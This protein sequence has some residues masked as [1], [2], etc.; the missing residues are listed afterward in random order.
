MPPRRK[1]PPAPA[2]TASLRLS[3]A[4]ERLAA[5]QMLR[6]QLLGK[7]AR[8]KAALELVERQAHA[9]VERFERE[10][11]R[12]VQEGMRLDQ[13]VHE[14]L[15]ALLGDG[16]RGKAERAAVRRVYRFLMQDQIITPR[17]MPG[18]AARGQ[19]VRPA[20]A[21][22]ETPQ[23]AFPFDEAEEPM[24]REVASAARP[25]DTK[26]GQLRTLFRRLADA[27]HPDKVQD[28]AEKA[29]CTELMKDITAAYRRGDLAKLLEIERRWLGAERRPGAA[30]APAT[31]D[32]TLEQ[33]V[34]LERGNDELRAQLAELDRLLRSARRAP[35]TKL[36]KSF[37]AAERD[38]VDERELAAANE[39]R[40][41]IA[42]LRELLAF[43]ERFARREI[44]LHEF[45]SGPAGARDPYE[46]ALEEIT[47]M[48]EAM[49]ASGRGPSQRS[50]GSR[51]R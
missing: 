20:P 42:T 11:Q 25:P 43:V 30:A 36:A 6:E 40:T 9:A 13:A 37:Q 15:C 16:A 39:A 44:S 14:A 21:P 18:E 10:R 24:E 47:A 22:W 8:R 28:E 33:A 31:D 34:A 4:A 27:F 1:T 3:E 12:L 29:A 7:V 46:E 38:G 32:E 23:E 49:L 48:A 26:H 45:M 35:E 19:Q 5:A 2:G 51:R 17:P 41:G 50:G